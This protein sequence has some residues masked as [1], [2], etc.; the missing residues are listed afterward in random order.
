MLIRPTALVRP[1]RSFE[2]ED[3]SNL[4]K[5]A[6]ESFRGNVQPHV[7]DHYIAYSCDIAARWDDG[8]VLVA[9]CDSRIVGT[10]TYA[11]RSLHGLPAEWAS[12]RT[13]AVHP[14]VRGRGLGWTLV[15]TC[16]ARAWEEGASTV[17]LHT[18]A[19]MTSA[20]AIYQRAGFERCPEYDLCASDVLGF[21][22]ALGDLAVIA[23][24]RAL[25]PRRG[26]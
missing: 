17:G 7:L 10:V 15:T 25:A 22:R 19:F 4:I 1:A 16:I 3:I 8:E 24:R 21:D 5:A 26:F 18:A 13:L 23:Y 6:L 20:L 9:E 12:F 14:S 2:V 11:A